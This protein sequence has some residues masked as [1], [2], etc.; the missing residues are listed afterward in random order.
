MVRQAHHERAKED[1]GKA[2]VST[3]NLSVVIATP[4][5]VP[6]RTTE[7]AASPR[8]ARNDSRKA[9]RPCLAELN[10]HR[11]LDTI[12]YGLTAFDPAFGYQ[13]TDSGQHLVLPFILSTDSE[14]I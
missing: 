2:P 4:V 3:Q 12:L 9:E 8:C 1:F 13:K 5:F 6:G 10:A 14:E 7:R 11:R